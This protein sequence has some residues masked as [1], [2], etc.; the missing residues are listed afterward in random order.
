MFLLIGIK[1]SKYL[2]TKM[3]FLAAE[4]SVGAKT[5]EEKQTETKHLLIYEPGTAVLCF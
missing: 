3:L 5:V 4:G 2:N 1:N